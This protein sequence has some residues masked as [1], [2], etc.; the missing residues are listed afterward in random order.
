[1]AGYDRGLYQM[2]LSR[3]PMFASCT[4]E[5]LDR[6][7]EL[8]DLIAMP[9]GHAIV[10]EGDSGESFFVL[11]SGKARIE[12][13]GREFATLGAGEYFGELALFDPA[14][15]NATVTAVGEVALVAMSREAFL[16][17]LDQ[18]PAI[19]DALLHGM[20]RRLHELDARV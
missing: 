4:S 6:L 10:S 14:P 11:T 16:R 19:R 17:A 5:Q 2:Y 20:A 8:G 9:D 15:R 13:G 18:I 1:M 7:A 12:R 3:V